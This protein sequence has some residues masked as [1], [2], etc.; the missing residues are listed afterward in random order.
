[1]MPHLENE[2]KDCR[3]IGRQHNATVTSKFLPLEHWATGAMS[4]S[5]VFSREE[6]GELLSLI[7]LEF[8]IMSGIQIDGLKIGN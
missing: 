2:I 3:S 8:S 6:D 1:M 5:S 7:Y 4:L